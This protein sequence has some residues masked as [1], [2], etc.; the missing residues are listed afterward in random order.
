[1]SISHR[2]AFDLWMKGI[3]ARQHFGTGALQEAR[4]PEQALSG[5]EG[6][7]RRQFQSHLAVCPQCGQDLRMFVR[8]QT[9]LHQ[10]WLQAGEP[11]RTAGELLQT[12]QNRQQATSRMSRLW[13]PVRLVAFTFLL[14]SAVLVLSWIL[15]FL[16]PEPITL[17]V[18]SP[19][20]LSTRYSPQPTQ[21]VTPEIPKTLIQPVIP[22]GLIEF[23]GW[24]PD[25]RYVLITQHALSGEANS[26][27]MYSSFFF[28]DT[29]HRQICP[30]GQPLLGSA[31]N[32][33]SMDWTPDGRL[34]VISP[35]DVAIYTPCTQDV[36]LITGL[37]D[38]PLQSVASSRGK[39]QFLL[40]GGKKSY[41]IYNTASGRVSR[42]EEL[43]PNGGS[44]DHIAWSPSGKEA[45]FSQPMEAG[46]QISLV[47]LQTGRLLEQVPFS[48]GTRQSAAWIEWMLP[49]VLM[50]YGGPDKTSLLLERQPGGLTKVTPNWNDRMGIELQKPGMVAAEGSYGDLQRGIF[51]LVL[52]YDTPEKRFIYLYHSD[53]NRLVTLTRDLNTILLF[54]DGQSM[55]LNILENEPAY[56]DVFHLIW[57]DNPSQSSSQVRVQGHTPRQYPQL[58]NAWDARSGRMAFGSTQGVSLVS[59]SDGHLVKFWKLGGHESSFTSLYLSPDGKNL[60]VHAN[61]GSGSQY[62][63]ES[64]VYM[65]ALP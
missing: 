47:D 46:S 29:G 61:I 55:P 24:S 14:V 38:E 64:E 53:G 58:T 23:E 52:A 49:D 41:W 4:L 39:S 36:E 34:L 54:P 13:V 31:Y 9:E 7:E 21:T 6:E 33:G 17:P 15:S 35:K 27:R 8:L 30:A 3:D 16:R 65:I 22:A 50:V 62:G 2:K 12:I 40:L 63:I 19:T 26:D 32:R 37:F 28:Y 20:I 10:R 1:M 51:H 57:V 25:S 60:A 5:L 59:L 56:N 42:L 48:S 45:A 11:H 18:A 43:I 44:A